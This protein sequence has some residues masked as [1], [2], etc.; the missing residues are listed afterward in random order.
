MGA[1]P[2]GTLAPRRRH[3]AAS[4]RPEGTP[5]PQGPP[6][7]PLPCRRSTAP[8]FLIVIVLLPSDS[9]FQSIFSTEAPAAKNLEPVFDFETLLSMAPP[10]ESG[11]VFL[12]D[13]VSAT[14]APGPPKG[15]VSR[16]QGP[17]SDRKLAPKLVPCPPSPHP[18]H[19]CTRQREWEPR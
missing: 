2:R 8:L 7:R 6:T 19:H 10:K 13:R 9:E 15:G 14:S 17:L 16:Q 18:R 4:T 3:G 1:P 11:T 12:F 5:T